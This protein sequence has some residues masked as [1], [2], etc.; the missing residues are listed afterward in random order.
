MKHQ[1]VLVLLHIHILGESALCLFI[2]RFSIIELR[3]EVNV[4]SI[5]IC[6]RN[7]SEETEKTNLTKRVFSSTSIIH[8]AQ[9]KRQKPVDSCFISLVEYSSIMT[10][11]M[12]VGEDLLSEFCTDF[13]MLNL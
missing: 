7:L 9:N 13:L 1:I 8:D 11:G 5:L 2:G 4:R 12:D 10:L 3:R 6:A